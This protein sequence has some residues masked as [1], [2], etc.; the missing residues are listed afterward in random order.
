MRPLSIPAALPTCARNSPSTSAKPRDF[1]AAGTTELLLPR[2]AVR[3]VGPIAFPLLPTQAGQLIAVA[4]RAPYGRFAGSV[5]SAK[6]CYEVFDGFPNRCRW[7]AKPRLIGLK[8]EL[9]PPC[10]ATMRST[11]QDARGLIDGQAGDLHHRHAGRGDV[12]MA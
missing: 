12:P 7:V 3:D 5:L 4:Q 10:A 8:S 6:E 11:V 9:Q 2:L 1:H